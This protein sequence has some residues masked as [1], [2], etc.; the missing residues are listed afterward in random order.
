MSALALQ[1]RALILTVWAIW[2]PG[3]ERSGDAPAIASA[4]AQV[5]VEDG[6]QAPVYESHDLDAVVMAV[7]ALRE[8]WLRDGLSGD[9]GRSWGVFQQP[10]YVGRADIV[11]QARAWLYTLHVAAEVCPE[12]PAAPLAGGCVQARVVADRRARTARR[13][14]A[15]ALAV[16]VAERQG[17]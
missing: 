5:V 2:Y 17:P 6:A 12:S 10:A 15:R 13:L 4:I 1:L 11:T 8:S 3:A 7:Y 16:G 14:L 9:G